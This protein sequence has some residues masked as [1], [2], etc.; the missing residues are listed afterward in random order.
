MIL[1]ADNGCEFS[2]TNSKQQ[3]QDHIFQSEMSDDLLAEVVTDIRKL[4]PECRMV[5]GSPHH[6]E[7]NGGVERVNRKGQEKLYAWMHTNNSTR[8]L[9]GCAKVAWQ[10]NTQYHHTVQNLSYVLTFGQ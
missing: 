5:T 7:S 3:K 4:W 1:Q 2:G 9:I 10:I 8:W 6:S